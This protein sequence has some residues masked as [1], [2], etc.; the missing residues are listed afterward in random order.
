[1][2]EMKERIIM[3][4]ISIFTKESPVLTAIWKHWAKT[5][6]TEKPRRYL[7]A[8]A[9]GHECDMFLWLGFR[10]LA[11]STFPPRMYRLFNRG[12][13]EEQVFVDELRGAGCQVW[14]TDTQTGLQWEFD[15]IG[16]HF[17]GHP[18]GVGL[19]IPGA[20]K[21]PHILEFKTHSLSSFN[22]LEKEGVEKSK[23]QHY[24]QVQVCMG[25]MHIERTLYVAVN[26]NTD[27]LYCE[28]IKFNKDAYT[29]LM[30]RAKKI[31]TG[32]NAQRCATRPEDYRCN[33]C[34]YKD[35]C[36]NTE[37]RLVML[38]K[39]CAIDCRSCCHAK[40]II[41]E[42][43]ARWS[44]GVGKATVIGRPVECSDHIF[45]PTIVF[46]GTVDAGADWIKFQLEDGSTF[47]HGGKSSTTAFSSDELAIMT[48]E[49][50]QNETVRAAKEALG[51]KVTQV[52]KV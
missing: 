13:R 5:Q 50:M 15:D 44:C 45:L 49:S 38:E 10:G 46:A 1:M 52:E 37:E 42:D 18:D 43:G 2:G 32:H 34:S 27:E 14:D 23:P 47:M 19:G 16:G 28:R 41:D 17:R 36:W 8:S 29:S 6:D 51:G 24:A 35:V 39:G 48:I 9:I 40:P 30:K 26:K 22:K 11:K 7:G 4:D 33:M 31:I 20:E 12:H 25:A 21:T 3:G